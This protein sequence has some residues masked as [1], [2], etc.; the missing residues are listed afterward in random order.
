MRPTGIVVLG[1]VL[2]ATG[3]AGPEPA[4]AT[5]AWT[6]DLTLADDAPLPFAFALEAGGDGRL[7]ATIRNGDERIVHERLTLEGRSLVWPLDPYDSRIEATLSDGGR[8][9]DGTWFKRRAGE[10]VEVP[11]AARRDDGARPSRPTVAVDGRWRVTFA[12]DDEDAVGLFGS[13]GDGS[14][15]GT[16]L[17]ATGDYRY[18]AGR[19]LAPDRFV[20][21]TFDGAHAFR[22][23]ARVLPD[24]SLDGTFRSGTW[25][26][27]PWTAV[28]DPDV[29]LDDGFAR[30]SVADAAALADLR[31]PDLDGRLRSA[32]DPSFGDGPRIVYV[33]GSWCPN[34]NDA[35]SLLIELRRR[36]GDRGLGIVG[37]AFELTG[38]PAEDTAAVRRYAA[39]RGVDWPILIA[40]PSDKDDATAAF[41]VLDRVR[42]FPTFL[43]VDP[44][45]AIR[46]VYSGFSGPATGAEHDRLRTAFEITIEKLLAGG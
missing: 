14:L 21:A 25:W 22:F 42:A 31:Y 17:T 32:L 28:R 8:A 18:L 40:G 11:F 39:H 41:P 6:G 7:R 23:E 12:S 15:R 20:L 37:L 26:V 34:C 45:G 5:G 46:A 36:F 38:D 19:A 3:C 16:F 30:T 43:F 9:L 27:D 35:T 44:D 33:F 29:A 10:V 2:V 1:C 24:G 4:L 13:G